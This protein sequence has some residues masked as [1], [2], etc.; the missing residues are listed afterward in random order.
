MTHE[1]E[2]GPRQGA[3]PAPC[4]G[5][6]P[7]DQLAAAANVKADIYEQA[8]ANRIRFW[9][10][11]A[12]RLSWF[13]EWQRPLDWSDP[14]YARW[15]LGG[16]LNVA[17]NCVDR[18]VEAGAGDRV[19]L[20]WEGA[21]GDVRMLTYADLRRSVCQAANALTALGVIRGDRVA[22]HLPMVPEAVVTMLA[23]ARIGAVHAVLPSA[24]DVAGLAAHVRDAGAK[25]VVTADGGFRDGRAPLA[26][27]APYKTA[28]YKTASYKTVPFKSVLDA[29][30]DLAPDSKVEHVV[31]VRRT[32]E[33]LDWQSGR[34]LW[35]HDTV[36][37]ADPEHRPPILYA[38][39]PLFI[40]YQTP[41]RGGVPG[42]F[43]PR[44]LLHTTGGY[45]TQVAFSHH[46]VFDHKAGR[47]V[48]WCTADIASISAHSYLVYGP[49]ANGATQVMYEGT[50]ETDEPGRIWQIVQ[51]YGV[52]VLFAA[53]AVIR[54]L[55]RGGA[56]ATRGE[57]SASRYDLSSLRIL[58]IDGG[59]V[60][61]DTWLWYRHEV[62]G[63]RAAVVGTWWQPETGAIMISPLPGVSSTK[64]GGAARPLPGVVADVLEDSG[65]EARRGAPGQL[66]MLEPWPS[67]A[68]TLWR[69]DERFAARYW[70]RFPGLYATGETARIDE[71]G[72]VWVLGREGR[73]G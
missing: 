50:A 65:A 68:R 8:R 19:A 17:Y 39:H 15:F 57:G 47:D 61:P 56:Q 28:S 12:R 59:P 6:P 58:G 33:R 29:A 70:S 41:G 43:E 48:Y 52:S 73:P 1:G 54:A 24:L 25:V 26:L 9:E 53:P 44:G 22:I 69:D 16:G 31:V 46:A 71:D 20:H 51:K 7:S 4:R 5:F 45:L 11:Q 35:W 66:V 13:V 23:C 3:A 72:D 32:G 62:G 63:D 37:T 67:M 34:D 40:S 55:R 21:P 2:Y 64:P 27:A 30:L 10:R 49:L 60:D 14:P 36:E 42:R 38:E 18:H